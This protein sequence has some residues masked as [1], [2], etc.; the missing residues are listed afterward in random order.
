VA[1]TSVE[2]AMSV[3]ADRYAGLWLQTMKDSAR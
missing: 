2:V 1:S 3:D